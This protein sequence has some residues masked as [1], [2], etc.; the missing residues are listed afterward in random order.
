MNDGAMKLPAPIATSEPFCCSR[1]YTVWFR[2]EIGGLA[3][4][5]DERLAAG[6]DRVALLVEDLL[7]AEVVD[8]GAA[9][10]RRP[11]RR[12]CAASGRP[13]CARG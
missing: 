4:L 2:S 13:R 3:G 12:R 6:V 5:V 10:L 11:G 8:D 7:A 1:S 9:L